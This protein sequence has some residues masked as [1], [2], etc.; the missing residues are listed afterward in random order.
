MPFAK[1]T[2]PRREGN[3]REA[4]G[5]RN[6]SGKLPHRPQQ[7]HALLR[8]AG[9]I[10]A[11]AGAWRGSEAGGQAA[12]RGGILQPAGH[13]PHH[14][15]PVHPPAGGGRPAD[16]LS[17]AGHVHQQ[18]QLSAQLQPHL[19]FEYHWSIIILRTFPHPL[20]AYPCHFEIL[21]WIFNKRDFNIIFS[22][23]HYCYIVTILLILG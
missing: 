3:G 18:A 19:Q 11:R 10:P 22:L 6:H 1:E 7:P 9:G 8:A 14:G 17:G 13:Q 2:A 4:R 5:D 21:D 20:N 12:L 23:K 16:A 15:A